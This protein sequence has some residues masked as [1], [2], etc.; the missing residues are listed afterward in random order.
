M[1]C[2]YEL[3]DAWKGPAWS[4]WVVARTADGAGTASFADSEWIVGLSVAVWA[5]DGHAAGVMADD[6]A[7]DE[8]KGEEWVVEVE[9]QENGV[10]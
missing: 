4:H 2:L 9:V 7:N 1:C 5:V 6:I 10:G 8:A 3:T